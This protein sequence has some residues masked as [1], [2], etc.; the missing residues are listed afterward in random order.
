MARLYEILKPNHKPYNQQVYPRA[1][2]ERGGASMS[3][4][5]WLLKPVQPRAMLEWFNRHTRMATA[6]RNRKYRLLAAAFARRLHG[7]D[8]RW[9]ADCELIELY[10][11]GL[12][13][14]SDFRAAQ[15]RTTRPLGRHLGLESGYQYNLFWHDAFLSAVGMLDSFAPRPGQLQTEREL[16]REILGNPF[17]PAPFLPPWR[18]D[19]A[20]ILSRQMYESGNFGAMP[21][22]ADALQDA[23]C[24]DDDILNHC[25]DG[26]QAHVRGCWVVD[27]VLGKV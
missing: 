5:E 8:A 15:E 26:N 19:T 16:I 13:S 23:G 18:T 7:R 4:E 9:V 25:R 14:H 10:V 20:T 3:E 24:E 11:E 6:A 12:A 21:I 2:G 1:D 22:L 27:L 17:Q